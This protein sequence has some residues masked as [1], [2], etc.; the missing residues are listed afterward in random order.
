M[1]LK[2]VLVLG[3]KILFTLG[4]ALYSF[5]LYWYGNTYLYGIKTLLAMD[6]LCDRFFVHLVLS[7]GLAMWLA[8][9]VKIIWRENRSLSKLL[10]LIIL[11]IGFAYI[12]ES[13]D[14]RSLSSFGYH[15]AHCTDSKHLSSILAVLYLY[16]LI[17]TIPGVRSK[18]AFWR[19]KNTP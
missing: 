14:Q 10:S 8:H 7:V 16:I 5:H 12:F 3:A 6:D 17:V 18:L 15:T 11:F 9:L 13:L 2:N 4:V 1:P 19:K